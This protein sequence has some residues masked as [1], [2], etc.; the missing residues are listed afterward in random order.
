[1]TNIDTHV[2]ATTHAQGA[3]SALVVS[4]GQWITSSDHKKIG[5]LF[6]GTSLLSAVLAAVLGLLFGL[7]RISPAHM[8]IFHGDATPQMFALY[9]FALVF[10]VLAPLF[11]ELPLRL[12]QL[13]L[14]H[15]LW[16][17]HASHNLVSGHG[18]LA[19]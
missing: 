8:E 18:S 7:E 12:F 6:I 4:V 13:N 14:V 15:A 9:Q 3:G 16:L 11:S 19:H 1:M 2:G 10:G 17:F 5:R